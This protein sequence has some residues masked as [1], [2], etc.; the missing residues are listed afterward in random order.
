MEINVNGSMLCM[1]AVSRVMS[2]QKPKTYESRRWGSRTLAR[3][4]IVNLGSISSYIAVPNAMPYIASKHAVI[5][6]T[7][8]AGLS[9]C[10]Y[11]CLPCDDDIAGFL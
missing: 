9:L 4:S 10:V 8:S 3:G 5:G 2:E 6:I 11:G 7:K 1:R